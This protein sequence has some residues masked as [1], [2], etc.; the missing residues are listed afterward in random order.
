MKIGE[1]TNQQEG[2]GLKFKKENA[3]PPCLQKS[4]AN[5]KGFGV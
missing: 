1:C 3:C 5:S 2:K 4:F